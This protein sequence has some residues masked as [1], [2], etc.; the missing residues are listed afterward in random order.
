MRS[1]V[2]MCYA[3]PL[4]LHLYS[5][6]E[7]YALKMKLYPANGFLARAHEEYG[8]ECSILGPPF[9]SK[10]TLELDREA[11]EAPNVV[12]SKAQ[13]CMWKLQTK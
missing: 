4:S 9:Q 13:P 3:Y 5:H 1:N 2:Y 7:M 10:I 12:L 8:T 6:D 11:S